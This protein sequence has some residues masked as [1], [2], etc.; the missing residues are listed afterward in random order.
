MPIHSGGKAA[1]TKSASKMTTRKK[2]KKKNKR[3]TDASV[4]PGKMTGRADKPMRF[5]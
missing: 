4:E 5:I 3:R 1:R 2:K